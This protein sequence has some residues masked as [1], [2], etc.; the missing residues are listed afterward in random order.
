[1]E[2][3][4]LLHRH[5]NPP[6]SEVRGRGKVGGYPP[7]SPPTSEVGGRRNSASTDTTIHRL[8]KLG[9][10]AAIHRLGEGEK[11]GGINQYKNI[12]IHR[13][14]RLRKLGE[15]R[16][17]TDFGSWGALGGIGRQNTDFGS[18]G[19]AP[20]GGRDPPI[21]RLR[22]LGEIEKWDDPPRPPNPPT[23]EVGGK[24]STDFGSR[25]VG[26][27]RQ[28]TD[29]GSWETESWGDTIHRIHRLRKLGGSWGNQ[30]DVGTIHR[31]RKSGGR[32]KKKWGELVCSPHFLRNSFIA[33]FERKRR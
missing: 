19:D 15:G 30:G 27:G 12:P 13:I 5:D 9:G 32:G 4:R 20:L 18:W 1:M 10:R 17:N 14:H 29:F 23:S 8:R 6:T 24:R 11:L 33:G 7:T 28:N 16:Q 2:D 31:L 21:H 3:H 22:K 25:G 26:E